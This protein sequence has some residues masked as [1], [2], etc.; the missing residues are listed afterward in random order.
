MKRSLCNITVLNVHTPCADKSDDVKA[1]FYGKLG[2]VFDR[3]P[4]YDMN[5]LLGDFNVK[6]GRKNIFKLTIGN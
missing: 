1:S 3:F 6:L 2:C 5:I 4:R